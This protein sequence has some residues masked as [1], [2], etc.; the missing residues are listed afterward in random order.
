MNTTKSNAFITILSKI[1]KRLKTNFFVIAINE[2]ILLLKAR[3]RLKKVKKSLP[4][5]V[6]Y[7][8]LIL[9]SAPEPK[10]PKNY[11][12]M[13]LICCNGSAANA[14]LLNL[15]KPTITV[16]DYE[17]VDPIISKKNNTRS[18]IVA[19]GLL[20]NIDLG[21][22]V[23]TQSNH[24]IGGAP[25]ILNAKL[26]GFCEIDKFTRRVLID[27]ITGTKKLERNVNTSLCSTGGFA[28][29][30]ALF[31]GAKSVSISGFTFVNLPSVNLKTHFYLNSIKETLKVINTRNHTLA[32]AALITLSILN[33]HKI[34]TVERDILPLTQ[35]WGNKK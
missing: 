2:K 28:I 31:L 35:N 10:L 34:Y 30:L 18:D 27:H 14:K 12:S 16:V 13:H 33:N 23:A 20:K 22:L 17:L 1:S 7:D 29:A 15:V 25:G 19:K 5:L 21:F 6:G 8:V 32:D 9:G 11:E 26:S 4:S 24:S 3:L